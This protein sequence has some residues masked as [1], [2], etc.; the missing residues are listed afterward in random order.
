MGLGRWLRSL[1]AWAWADHAQAVPEDPRE[2]LDRA[3]QRQLELHGQVRESLAGV[4]A[5]GKRV[6]LQARQLESSLGRLEARA[7]AL[8][9]EGDD[10]AASGTLVRRAV[11]REQL[12]ELAEHRQELSAEESKMRAAADR[13]DLE[14]VR[15]RA[16]VEAIKDSYTAAEARARLGDAVAMPGSEDFELRMALLRAQDLVLAT[17]S[18][19]SVVDRLL[20]QGGASGAA[21]APD[22]FL[23]E[24]A[25][26]AA[27]AEA[28][29]EL[30][31]LRAELARHQTPGP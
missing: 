26:S 15:L 22:A 27:E 3:Y 23:R 14:A 13:L 11:L 29:N 12:A 18:R 6:E 24:L 5:A 2:I 20:A 25:D 16:R 9:A 1:F 8:L 17:R 10:E 31:R 19:A 21:L 28:S 30:A 4:M 7:S